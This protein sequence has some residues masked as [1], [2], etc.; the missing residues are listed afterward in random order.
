MGTFKHVW[1]NGRMGKP[2]DIYLCLCIDITQGVIL[3]GKKPFHSCVSHELGLSCSPEGGHHS[4]HFLSPLACVCMIR[5]CKIPEVCI[6][7][8]TTFKLW[9][10][11][12]L[13][14]FL[15]MK[16]FSKAS[17]C[18]RNLS[19]GTF[20]CPVIMLRGGVGKRIRMGRKNVY[21]KL[22]Q[23]TKRNPNHHVLPCKAAK[24]LNTEH[25]TITHV[26]KVTLLYFA[27]Q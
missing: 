20:Y 27:L 14:P 25:K 11:D 22:W 1:V 8:C 13:A 5:S 24:S 21:E 19:K 4:H 7:P 9:H 15:K 18:L 17:F 12:A 6:S 23:G 16:I 3:G 2:F 10:A 26:W